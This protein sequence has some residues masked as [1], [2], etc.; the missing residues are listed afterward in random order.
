MNG[1][2]AL[3]KEAQRALLTLL[4]RDNTPGRW[5]SM[6]QEV[7]PHQTKNRKGR[8]EGRKEGKEVER[9]ERRMGRQAGGQAGQWAGGPAGKQASLH[10]G[11]HWQTPP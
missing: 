2:G 5:P 4:S 1:I 6:N 7:G 9:E 8:K 11:K 10:N 3:T